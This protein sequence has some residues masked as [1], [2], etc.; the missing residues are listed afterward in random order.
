MKKTTK[1][2]TPNITTPAATTNVT[3]I[4]PPSAKNTTSSTAVDADTEF[5][6]I[7]LQQTPKGSVVYVVKT[8]G[9]EVTEFRLVSEDPGN[10]YMATPNA[11]NLARVEFVKLFILDGLEDY[12]GG[13]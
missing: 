13:Y 2:Q 1:P 12:F 3:A 4:P 6:S 11:R 8:Q 5:V 7:G 9:G 10:P